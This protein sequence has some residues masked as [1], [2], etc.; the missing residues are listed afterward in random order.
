MER[1][2]DFRYRSPFEMKINVVLMNGINDDELGD[3]VELT[4]N[5]PINV[6]FIEFM[7]FMVVDL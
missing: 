3:F 4:R 2:E 1:E 7:P 6:R 5:D